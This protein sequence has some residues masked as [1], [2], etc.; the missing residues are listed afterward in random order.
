MLLQSSGSPEQSSAIICHLIPNKF[1]IPY[2]CYLLPITVP[3]NFIIQQFSVFYQFIIP[4]L[5]FSSFRLQIIC[6]RLIWRK[7]LSALF[8]QQ[9]N[10][11]SLLSLL[12]KSS[13]FL[14]IYIFRPSY[15]FNYLTGLCWA[16]PPFQTSRDY[17][18]LQ[19]IERAKLWA[20][21]HTIISKT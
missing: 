7:T 12:N 3:R 2:T 9:C 1:A 19:H 4:F 6:N 21:N 20:R 10:H 17:S 5:H 11:S 15:L 13:R 14:H 8:R 16:S 18:V